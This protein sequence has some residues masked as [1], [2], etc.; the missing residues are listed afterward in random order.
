[1]ILVLLSPLAT[2][3]LVVVHHTSWERFGYPGQTYGAVSALLDAGGTT[4]RSS[5]MSGWR[6][7]PAGGGSRSSQFIDEV[8]RA[9]G[10]DVG[11]PETDGPGR[12]AGI[13]G[14]GCGGARLAA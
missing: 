3:D 13:R 2:Y 7:S 4:G 11:R 5:A 6:S 10:R 12:R 14:P 9:P 1:M 8:S